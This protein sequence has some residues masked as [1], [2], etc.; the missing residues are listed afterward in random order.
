MLS[1]ICEICYKTFKTKQHLNQHKNRK[2]KCKPII[3]NDVYKNCIDNLNINTILKNTDT[4]EQIQSEI[5]S[6]LNSNNINNNFEDETTAE[7]ITETTIETTT[8][9][10]NNI[11]N[12]YDNTNENI[13]FNCSEISSENNKDK[14]SV[15]NLTV[16]NMLEFINNYQKILE[17]K[18]KMENLLVILK[19]K[20]NKLATENFELK[21]Q[22]NIVNK[23]IANYKNPHLESQTQTIQYQYKKFQ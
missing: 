2:R 20:V 12:Y 1:H 17:E 13:F 5:S 19:K 8:E 6:N 21:T 11:N 7:T 4:V 10:T 14:L 18:N 22:I 3:P 16:T 23:F 9:T 15:E